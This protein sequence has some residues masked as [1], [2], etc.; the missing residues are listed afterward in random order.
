MASNREE[1]RHTCSYAI[2]TFGL[3]AR[4]VLDVSV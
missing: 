4:N 3:S 1:V 2:E